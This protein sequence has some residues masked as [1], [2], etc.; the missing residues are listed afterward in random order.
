MEVISVDELLDRLTDESDTAPAE[1][2]EETADPTEEEVTG[3]ISG[4][5]AGMETAPETSAGDQALELLESIQQD[6]HHPFLET[7]FQ[8]YTVTEGLLL[9]ALLLAFIAACFKMLK[10]GFS[11]L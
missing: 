9:L 10:G 4:E 5:A 1:T 8:D 3:E 7:D 2:V 6:I 11:W